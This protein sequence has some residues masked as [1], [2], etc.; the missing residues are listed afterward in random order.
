MPVL[1][2]TGR[3]FLARRLY[4]FQNAVASFAAMFKF[5]ETGAGFA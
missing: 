1:I 4:R 5:S 2:S 3:S